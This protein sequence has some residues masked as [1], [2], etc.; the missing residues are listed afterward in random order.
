MP[1]KYFYMLH[2]LECFHTNAIWMTLWYC[3]HNLV[4]FS[5]LLH[6]KYFYFYI[7]GINKSRL[8]SIS[9]K[10]YMKEVFEKLVLLASISE[11]FYTH[12][13]VLDAQVFSVQC[14]LWYPLW[15]SSLTLLTLKNFCLI[16]LWWKYRKK[17][18]FGGVGILLIM[19]KMHK[20]TNTLD[21]AL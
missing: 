4:W 10:I 16:H 18:M 17:G 1:I 14:V 12:F 9:L 21:T 11:E 8:S 20:H 3:K 2:D 5:T 13:L 19:W 15:I 7:E 6:T